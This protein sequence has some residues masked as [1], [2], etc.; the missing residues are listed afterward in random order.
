ML[1][2]INIYQNSTLNKSKRKN[3]A[4]GMS[5]VL[6][7]ILLAGDIYGQKTIEIPMRDGIKL[8]ADLYYPEGENGP[9]PVILMR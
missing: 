9:F 4:F 8:A 2:M 5:I 1:K 7:I 6:L 3:T